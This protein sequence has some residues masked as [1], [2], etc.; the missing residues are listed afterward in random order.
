MGYQPKRWAYGVD[1]QKIIREWFLKTS[2]E[3]LA[4]L[5]LAGIDLDDPPPE[6]FLEPPQG[7]SAIAPP[8]A[9]GDH[10]DL[11][12]AANN[13]LKALEKAPP[14]LPPPDP[15]H[16]VRTKTVYR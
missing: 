9:R 2:V 5:V 11:R 14:R 15:E 7:G 1:S 8:R 13:L 3:D 4:D 16:T 6:L 10:T 12:D